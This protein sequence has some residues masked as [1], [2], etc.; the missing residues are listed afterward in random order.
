M[1]SCWRTTAPAFMGGAHGVAARDLNRLADERDRARERLEALADGCGVERLPAWVHRYERP[2][3]VVHQ[4]SARLRNPP[5]IWVFRKRT[6]PTRAPQA[7]QVMQRAVEVCLCGQ[8]L[9]VRQGVVNLPVLG[10]A[11]HDVSDLLLGSHLS[12]HQRRDRQP[13]RRH[14]LEDLSVAVVACPRPSSSLGKRALLQLRALQT[15]VVRPAAGRTLD[16]DPRARATDTGDCAAIR[17]RRDDLS[18]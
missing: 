7:F 11:D 5:H 6:P 10:L 13:E 3:T 18:A 8:V 9:A 17:Q 14:T 4:R 15:G 1:W 2:P 12:Q 16:V